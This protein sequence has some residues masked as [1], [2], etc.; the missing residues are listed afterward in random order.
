MNHIKKISAVAAALL[1]G[2]SSAYVAQAN[3]A[4]NSEST[5]H[6]TTKN[7]ITGNTTH[8][9]TEKRKMKRDVKAADGSNETVGESQTTKT[10]TKYDSK[11]KKI[12]ES[13]KTEVES[14]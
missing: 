13:K 8:T 11:G 3:D 4:E 14:E 1:M 7:P 6:D 12:E 2:V 5:S 10:K 9:K